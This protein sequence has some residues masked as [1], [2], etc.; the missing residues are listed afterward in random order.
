M[1][2]A[3]LLVLALAAGVALAPP[4]RADEAAAPGP[5]PMPLG[6]VLQVA[7]RQNPSLELAAID[8][9]IADAAVMRASGIDDWVLNGDLTL[10]RFHT[11]A[12]VGGM[13]TSANYDSL[14]VSGSISRSLSTGGSFSVSVNSSHD[15]TPFSVTSG[16]WTQSILANVT[17]PLLQGRGKRIARAAVRRSRVD[18]DAA[19]LS[20]RSQAVSVLSDVINAYYELAYA[21]R[22]LEIQQASLELAVERLRITQAS[23]K[24]GATAPSEATAVEQTI[25]SREQGVANA[26]LAVTT[27]SLAL[28]RM[29]GLEIGPGNID[30]AT[31]APLSAAPASLDLKSLLDSAYANSPEIAVLAKRAEGATIDVEVADDGVMTRLDAALRA[32][33]TGVAEGFGGAALDMVKFSGYVVRGELTV[34]HTL[35]NRAARAGARSARSRV[36]QAKINIADAKLQVASAMATAIAQA[37]TAAKRIELSRHEVDLAEKNIAAEQS[38]FDLGRSTNFDIAQRQDELRQAQLGY[39]RANVDY[40]LAQISIDSITGDLLEKY[41]VTLAAR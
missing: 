6:E 10:N 23:I 33:P 17:Q 41:G 21:K 5:Q 34:E 3:P 13:S 27:R 19:T 14:D 2:R 12:D 40:L 20:R 38:R 32:G 37:N 39:A 29:V 24:A 36:T 7:I 18:L 15:T 25:A 1:P 31:A 8:V 9:D 22:S 11:T 35:G 4:A 16:Q 26:E 30:L 28:R